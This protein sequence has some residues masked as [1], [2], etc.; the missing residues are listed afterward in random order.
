LIY[1]GDE[2]KKNIEYVRNALN[3]MYKEY[4]DLLNKRDEEGSSRTSVDQNGLILKPKNPRGG[5]C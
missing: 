5:K 3:E 4:V 2:A 1:P